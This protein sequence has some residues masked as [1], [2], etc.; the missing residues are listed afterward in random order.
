[1]HPDGP[2]RA[3]VYSVLVLV[4]R[5]NS[6]VGMQERTNASKRNAQ[7]LEKFR[8]RRLGPSESEPIYPLLLAC[9]FGLRI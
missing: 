6:D 2:T 7:I 3:K 4:L 5:L 1:M 9:A 8:L